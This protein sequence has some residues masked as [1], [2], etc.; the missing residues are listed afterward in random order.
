MKEINV[1]IFRA[2][3]EKGRSLQSETEA[4]PIAKWKKH[5]AYLYV[6]ACMCIKK[7]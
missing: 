1:R 7:F 5:G 6:I 2:A 4:S 3:A